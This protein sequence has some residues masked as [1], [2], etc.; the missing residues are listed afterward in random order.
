VQDVESLAQALCREQPPTA[1]A[2][3]RFAGLQV[4]VHSNAPALIDWLT[5]YYHGHEAAAEDQPDFTVTALEMAPPAFDVTFQHWP[6]DGGKVGPK[7]TF[8]ELDG[9]RL[10]RK[11][12][13]GMQF[14]VAGNQG[15]ATCLA[16]GPCLDN[17]NQVVNFINAQFIGHLLRQDWVLCHAAGVCGHGTGLALAGLSGGGKSTLALHLVSQ[18]LDFVSN[19]RLLVRRQGTTT[20]MSGVPKHPRINPGTILNNPDLAPAMPEERRAALADLPVDELWPLEEK[21]DADIEALY[22]AGRV[23]LFSAVHGLIILNWTRG[24]DAPTRLQPVALAERA[25]L[26]GAVMKN[27]GPFH[28]WPAGT[29]L[30]PAPYLRHLHGVPT[31]EMTGRVDFAAA[32]RLCRNLPADSPG[33]RLGAVAV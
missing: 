15:H 22:G 16:F 17:P 10:V 9:G 2:H 30:D 32:T 5:A 23:R 21:Y 33:S 1:L 20:V 29:P 11:V 8:V 24:G 31:Y 4:A 25:D 6:R 3:F 18:G 27:P 13:T 19:D 7:D 12:R 28:L 26:L 14:L